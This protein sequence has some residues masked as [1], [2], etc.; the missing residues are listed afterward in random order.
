MNTLEIREVDKLDAALSEGSAVLSALRMA[1]ANW[2]RTKA[3]ELVEELAQH[4]FDAKNIFNSGHRS[5]Q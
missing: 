5:I 3:L 2:E 4:W 1:I